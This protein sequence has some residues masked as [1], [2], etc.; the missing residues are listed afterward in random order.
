MYIS[1]E[2]KLHS[3]IQTAISHGLFPVWRPTILQY[4]QKKTFVN[5]V[6][7]VCLFKYYYI[8]FLDSKVAHI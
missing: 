7:D 4:Y 3:T 2:H 8:M 5:T 1:V 6:P